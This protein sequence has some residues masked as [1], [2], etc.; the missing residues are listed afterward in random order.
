[1]L[2]FRP[3]CA[4]CLWCCHGE[5]VFVSEAE[6]V[7]LGEDAFT[8]RLS[9]DDAPCEKLDISTGLCSVHPRRPIECRLFPLDLLAVEGVVCWVV[10]HGACPATAAMTR[11]HMSGDM[12]R[13]ERDLDPDW[14]QAYIEHHRVNQPAKYRPGMFT[15]LRAYRPAVEPSVR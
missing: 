2:D 10:W 6:Q 15:V 8:G 3:Y 12:D 1:M 5:R 4:P 13:W 14:V 11:D 9:A 7:A